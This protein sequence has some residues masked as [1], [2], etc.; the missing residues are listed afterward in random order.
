MK[1]LPKS[2]A[3]WADIACAKFL[4]AHPDPEL[5]LIDVT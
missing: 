1:S 4:T 3:V 5:I 2:K